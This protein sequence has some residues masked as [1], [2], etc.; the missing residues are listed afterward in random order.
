MNG[1]LLSSYSCR[2]SM[3]TAAMNSKEPD[4]MKIIATT[5][6]HMD[7]QT[8][9]NHYVDFTYPK[10]SFSVVHRE[11]MRQDLPG[12][13]GR[14]QRRITHG[15]GGLIGAVVQIAA[16]DP[17]LERAALTSHLLCM[18]G[19]S[20][21]EATHAVR[22]RR[23]HIVQHAPD[24]L[25]RE[26]AAA[27]AVSDPCASDVELGRD[28]DAWADQLSN[29]PVAPY[30]LALVLGV[31]GYDDGRRRL[32]LPVACLED[33]AGAPCI[34]RQQTHVY[35]LSPDTCWKVFS[36]SACG[37]CFAAS[38]SAQQHVSKCQGA[39]AE[40]VLANWRVS[41]RLDLFG[42]W[43]VAHFEALA[44]C[45][46]DLRLW[47]EPM[48]EFGQLY[49]WHGVRLQAAVSGAQCGRPTVLTRADVCRA[50]HLLHGSYLHVAHG[51]PLAVGASSKN[52]AVFRT[53]LTS[54]PLMPGERFP[55]S[56]G[57][58]TLPGQ[59]AAFV[60]C[61]DVGPVGG[62][63][64]PL[65]AGGV[66]G[67]GLGQAGGAGEGG[68]RMAEYMRGLPW[69]Q[70]GVSSTGQGL[71][72]A[73]VPR[74]LLVV[75]VAVGH[76]TAALKHHL[77]SLP[78]STSQEVH[79]CDL[80]S[81]RLAVAGAL[82][83]DEDSSSV[84]MEAMDSSV[85]SAALVDAMRGVAVGPSALV[86]VVDWGLTSEQVDVVGSYFGVLA[87]HR[88][89]A[90]L[91]MLPLSFMVSEGMAPC[92]SLAAVQRWVSTRC[93]VSALPANCGGDAQVARCLHAAIRFVQ[94]W[95]SGAR[96]AVYAADDGGRVA[97][98]VGM[99]LADAAVVAAQEAVGLHLLSLTAE[100]LGMLAAMWEMQPG[101]GR[102]LHASGVIGGG[103]TTCYEAFMAMARTMPG[104]LVVATAQ[105]NA[106]TLAV[107]G[108]KCLEALL[109]LSYIRDRVVY[110]LSDRDNN[111]FTKPI[112]LQHVVE[113]L[114]S[115]DIRSK[116]VEKLAPLSHLII[117]EVSQ[118][119]K[120]LMTLAV[121][122][123]MLIKPD[124]NVVIGG[125]ARQIPCPPEYNGSINA[126]FFE[127]VL[128]DM[129]GVRYCEVTRYLRDPGMADVVQALANGENAP[130]VYHRL[131][132]RFEDVASVAMPP[133]ATTLHVF[134]KN[135]DRNACNAASYAAGLQS[136]GAV[137][138]RIPWFVGK[139]PN[140]RREEGYKAAFKYTLGM[141][142]CSI[143]RNCGLDAGM[144]S[145]HCR[146]YLDA[147]RGMRV[148]FSHSCECFEHVQ[149][150][151]GVSVTTA[152]RR[153][154]G[155]GQLGEVVHFEEVPSA[156]F[157]QWLSSNV[158]PGAHGWACS[159]GQHYG[160]AV[161]RESAVFWPVVLIKNKHGMESRV[162]VPHIV[163]RESRWR[164]L[165]KA[166]AAVAF[167]PLHLGYAVNCQQ[168]QGM[169]LK[170][171]L[172]YLL[173]DITEAYWLQG[174]AAVMVTRTTDL[175]RLLF[176]VP[177]YSW[178]RSKKNWFKVESRVLLWLKAC[179]RTGWASGHEVG[180]P[181]VDWRTRRQDV[182]AKVFM[183]QE[184]TL[185][186][187]GGSADQLRAWEQQ[188]H[189]AGGVRAV[190]N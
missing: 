93:S 117:D 105:T 45:W 91:P 79:C 76:P 39:C 126:F 169:T 147:F 131:M 20:S 54:S 30:V 14:L 51:A 184:C 138:L 120:L 38:R 104:W 49:E 141:I 149:L 189:A 85:L 11:E 143:W 34:A 145:Y 97:A 128:W 103:K 176:K 77:L 130:F 32:G 177:R 178:A 62:G 150:L 19:A 15:A 13:S 57:G 10:D 36:C 179:Q 98:F 28:D 72:P 118:V 188:F 174:L 21:K 81:S 116:L 9:L 73:P 127:S 148:I 27:L 55:E 68:W 29:T 25:Y 37:C 56:S 6:K 40:E 58:A 112:M 119:N 66:T 87:Q 109:E 175:M 2:K 144:E 24:A 146:P 65:N 80:V 124:L 134:S 180:T 167:V 129:L 75:R 61:P 71:V 94:E 158:Q 181:D 46:V 113:Y 190:G 16:C 111:E 107:N 95:A 135:K 63:Q 4:L 114:C 161:S 187:I 7:L 12:P 159:Y 173:A 48:F 166:M 183:L 133:G 1:K 44:R 18:C 83:D 82:G 99:N 64:G 67:A 151:P 110:F 26:D 22:R 78:S 185:D 115:P 155:K 123:V 163:V 70:Q 160:A 106:G 164:G 90:D 186:V 74:R 154:V 17:V 171:R 108:D 86:V 60:Q 125:D 170:D 100:Q 89:V 139:P 42:F 50:V 23:G 121:I 96:V 137:A 136:S 47:Q 92:C 168:M 153:Q 88:H 5:L 162:V 35:R 33:G 142:E 41:Q 172:L 156:V 31:F 152:P 140:H 53:G 8:T 43:Q 102:W 182:A 122:V 59:G 3:A 52:M 132:P 69:R 165:F 157:N 84:L 101:H